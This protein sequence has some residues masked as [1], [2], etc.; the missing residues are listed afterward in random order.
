MFL[1]EGDVVYEEVELLW[2]SGVGVLS[3]LS[4][5]LY[6]LCLSSV[7]V[8]VCLVR[9]HA[10]CAARPDVGAMAPVGLSLLFN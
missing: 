5:C 9:W 8:C 10:T 3:L 4:L 1:V 6:F 2:C 7:F